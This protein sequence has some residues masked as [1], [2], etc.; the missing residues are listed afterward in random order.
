M[1]D[2]TSLEVVCPVC[3]KEFFPET[4][5]K[6]AKLCGDQLYLWTYQVAKVLECK[7][8]YFCSEECFEKSQKKWFKNRNVS[9]WKQLLKKIIKTNLDSGLR[10]GMRCHD[11]NNIS[12]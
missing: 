11:L 2:L 9:R 7:I 10:R 4:A 3:K 12:K 1:L 8:Y 6:R 5:I